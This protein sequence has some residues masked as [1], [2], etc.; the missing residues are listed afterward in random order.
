MCEEDYDD[1]QVAAE[2][3]A[4]QEMIEA[5]EHGTINKAPYSCEKCG[6]A[7]NGPGSYDGDYSSDP[8]HEHLGLCNDCIKKIIR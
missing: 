7:M 5:L 1:E 8:A 3:T 6:K 2:E 4:Y